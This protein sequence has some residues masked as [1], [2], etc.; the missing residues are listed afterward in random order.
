M[1]RVSNAHV[2]WMIA[3]ILVVGAITLAGGA[4]ADGTE[5]DDPVELDECT[6][7]E[8]PGE[9]VL[10]DDIEYDGGACIEV[11]DVE[12]VEIDGQGNGLSGAFGTGL[13]VH[14]S[15]DIT[16]QNLRIDGG[17]FNG[18]LVQNSSNVTIVEITVDAGEHGI[19]IRDG[20]EQ[21]FVDRNTI[22]T[23]HDTGIF[24]SESSELNITNNYVEDTGINSIRVGDGSTDILIHGNEIYDSGSIMAWNASDVEIIEN[25]VDH[26]QYGINVREGSSDVV[27]RNNVVTNTTHCAFDVKTNSRNVLIED[28]YAFNHSGVGL[29]G[30]VSNVTIRNNVVEE[31][32]GIEGQYFGSI[33]AVNSSYDITISDNTIINSTKDGIHLS[34]WDGITY[35]IAVQNNTIVGAQA[36][37]IFLDDSTQNASVQGNQLA[38]NQIGIEDLN[39]AENTVDDNTLEPIQLLGGEVDRAVVTEGEL[40]SIQADLE[41]VAPVKIDY[42]VRLEIDGESVE[43][44]EYA[45]PAQSE[46]SV[47]LEHVFTES[48]EYTIILNG[49][50]V[51]TVTVAAEE[52]PTPTPDTTSPTPEQTPTQPSD[53]I[54]GFGP[55]AVLVA[56]CG[57]AYL[58]KRRLPRDRE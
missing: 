30:N 26:V 24:A 33:H 1:S 44:K 5:D 51:G 32:H 20:S 22:T 45:V 28:N 7:I 27:V 39:A 36:H 2:W 46:I 31:G 56:I 17:E 41:N 16:V 15:S 42:E 12:D 13:G 40:V 37:G 10:T 11:R 19:S 50:N 49:V 3:I 55:I 43:T 48:G 6:V 21:I 38:N 9:Y 47:D 18:L 52:T 29:E 34:G 8:S 57:A 25:T 14:D 23:D 58:L 53:D 4:I 54:P 35:D